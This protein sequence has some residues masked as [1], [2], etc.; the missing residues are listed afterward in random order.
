MSSK[1]DSCVKTD[2]ALKLGGGQAQGRVSGRGIQCLDLS[3]NG[4]PAA[5]VLQAGVPWGSCSHL[6]EKV[7]ETENRLSH[8]QSTGCCTT[9]HLRAPRSEVRFWQD[10]EDLRL[11]ELSCFLESVDAR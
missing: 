5:R 3:S 7:L 4:W 2:Q 1:R 11:G 10:W 6:Q 9:G 8:P